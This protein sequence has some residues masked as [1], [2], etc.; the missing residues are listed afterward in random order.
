MLSPG[1]EFRPIHVLGSLYGNRVDWANDLVQE[2][3]WNITDLHSPHS[4]K[5]ADPEF[6][7][8]ATPFGQAN[9]PFIDIPW[10]EI[11]FDGY[12]DDVIAIALARAVNVRRSQEAVPLVIHATYRPICKHEQAGRKDPLSLRKLAGEGTP[13]ERKVVLGWL[14]DTRSFT[15]HLQQEKALFWITEIDNILS[16]GKRIKA[17]TLENIS[18]LNHVGF[19]IPQSRYF[20]N[21][22]RHTFY[23]A[24][25]HGPQH[26]GARVRLDLLLWKKFL[27]SSAQI[28]TNINLITFTTWSTRIITDACETGLGGYNIDTGRG[29]RLPLPAWMIGRFQ[30]NFLEFLSSLIGLWLE[31]LTEPPKHHRYLCLT[32]SSSA[33]GWLYKANFNPASQQAQDHIARQLAELL[34]EHEAGLYS[35]HIKGKYNIVADSLSR[36]NHLPVKQL[37]FLLNSL[38]PSQLPAP[39]QVSEILPPAIS[40]FLDS[41]R[42]ISTKPKALPPTP[43]PSSLGALFDGNNSWPSLTSTTNSL[44]T[45][46]RTNGSYSCLSLQLALDTMR[47]AQINGLA[48][49]E[50]QSE[51][52][53]P[54]NVRPT[55]Q[56]HGATRF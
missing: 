1:S 39:L 8:E 7:P 24:Q 21:R 32:D 53:F 35:Q 54:M 12:I 50:I 14:I 26:I 42:H 44:T 6:L 55:G 22:I 52:P 19:V 10:H 30:I 5:L 23:Q 33:V 9:P 49:M 16:C 45:T 20:L 56:T 17:K 31:L 36:D 37:T 2:P 47:E 4:P 13:N 46:L 51:P 3:T 34:L 18:K 43:A 11:H 48:Y 41:L 29:W 25:I 28:G 27:A 15:I 38:Y 40:S